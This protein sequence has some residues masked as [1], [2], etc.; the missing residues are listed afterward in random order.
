MTNYKEFG[1]FD[2]KSREFVVNRADTPR[3]WINYLSNG[4]YCVLMS[5]TGGG[6]S[7][8]LDP[9]VNR[10]TRWAPAN[11]LSDRPGRYVY[12]RDVETGEFFSG[13][14]APVNK[15]ERHECRHGLG[16][17][18]IRNRYEGIQVTTTFFVPQKGRA[19]VWMVEVKNT[20]R[21]EREV[22]VFPF[23]EWF[24]GPCEPELCA[25]NLTVLLNDGKF[26]EDLQAIWVSKF[27][28]ANKEWPYYAYMGS[29][30]KVDGFDLDY[31]EFIGPSGDYGCPKALVE[32]GCSNSLVRGSNMVGVLQHRIALKRGESCSFS[33]TVG[34]AENEEEAAESL[35]KYR[36]WD[37][38]DKA[39]QQTKRAFRKTVVDPLQIET[40]DVELDD[41]FN[42]WLKYQVL[43]NNHWG[44]AASYYHDGLGEFGY[45]NTAQDAWA[46]LPLDID[47]ARKRM[48]KLAEHQL[49]SGQPMAGW[50]YVE[51][52]SEGSAPADFPIWLPILVNAYIKETGDAPLLD[53]R[54]PYYDGGS[55]TLYMH[56]CKAVQFLQDRAKSKRGLPLM[57]TQDWNDAFD[58][59]G[60]G[61]KGE[62]VWLAMGLCVGLKQLAEMAAYIGD[63]ERIEECHQRYD[64]MKE[65]INKYAWAGDRYVYAYND[66]GEPIGSPVNEEGSCQLN[67][68]TWALLAEIPDEE[69]KKKILAHI[70]TTL[71]TP[72]GP[73]LFTPPY[74]KYNPDIGRI[75]AFAPG[76]KENA[77]V[78]IHGGTFKAMMDYKLGRGDEAYRTL[79]QI[80]PNAPDKDIDIYKTE[81]YVFPEYVIGPGNPRYGE[82][83]FTWLTGSA[84]WF[85]VVVMEYL[86]GI[87][88][89]F[90][91]LMIDPCIPDHWKSMRILRRFRGTRYDIRI[92]NPDG[93]KR[94]IKQ[95]LVD[96][97]PLRGEV[98]PSF[99]DR[100]AHIVDVTMG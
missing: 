38:C 3:P 27:P 51:G 24:L 82:G 98:L 35:Q 64:A 75:T 59:T 87:R 77:S 55:D 44:R 9:A 80:M 85:M 66:K 10:I 67:A 60:I 37:V 21:R 42:H 46:L 2:R 8:Y 83:A 28:W 91:G 86:L 70:D 26:N 52:S 23:V 94:G 43:M 50:S 61:G 81:P 76:T 79:R 45:R 17:T 93:V 47:F 15:S 97:E 63:T 5:Q 12:V 20:S 32:G 73:T 62:S 13:M 84:D 65:L 31:E 74:T 7:F 48:L 11:Y 49:K 95:I 29:S 54:I 56:V 16:Y 78:F 53:K 25:R 92:E 33:V 14:S 89:T 41:F 69:Q 1:E 34:L 57:G 71:D 36:N 58:R 39:Y 18:R 90:D 68:L 40:P 4:E 99:N 30:L 22:D 88:P 19:E 100:R 6:Y 96:D 72:Y